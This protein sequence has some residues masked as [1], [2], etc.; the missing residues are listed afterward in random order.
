MAGLVLEGGGAKGSYHIGAWKALRELGIEIEGVA[1][2]SVGALNGAWIVQDDFDM[3]WQMWY[4][5]TPSQVFKGDEKMMNKIIRMDLDSDDF[6]KLRGSLK[7]IITEGGLDITP[8]RTLVHKYLKEDAIRKSG[9]V[10]GFVT[11]SLTD[12]KPIDVYT[13]DVPPG[14]LAEYL[15]ASANLPIFKLERL[16]GKLYIDG[17]FYDNLPVRL[18]QQKG[19]KEIICV[20]SQGLGIKQKIDSNGLQ[21][22][23]ISPSENVGRTLELIPETLRRNLQMG[24][25]DTL[26][27]YRHYH[28]RHYYVDGLRD[29][30][31]Y[32]ERFSGVDSKTIAELASL[33]GLRDKSAQRLLFE[34]LI[35]KM[36]ELLRLDVNASYSEIALALI[37]YGAEKVGIERFQI[38]SDMDLAGKLLSSE[39]LAHVAEHTRHWGWLPGVLK[40]SGL[41]L[42][43]VKDQ[44]L[45][46]VLE[47]LLRP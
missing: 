2:T 13:E 34:D 37:E 5:M 38:L 4:D 35:P 46:P 21:L 18:L 24:Y 12:F 9:K 16:D 29:E 41:Y 27:V 20:E 1:G 42:N 7:R 44:V 25:Y 31:F 23:H 45:A 30:R 3:A 8:L 39:P 47:D 17:G 26:K 32:I 19:F 22:T 15:M 14:M 28:G 11:V 10:F 6:N 40:S 36:C 43:T 33:L